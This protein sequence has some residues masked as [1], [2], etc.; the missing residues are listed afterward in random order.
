MYFSRIYAVDE[1]GN[2]YESLYWQRCPA[3]GHV[4]T[5]DCE[6]HVCHR[7]GRAKYENDDL[8]LVGG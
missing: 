4:S 5:P 8:Y 2:V 6:G 7:C 1:Q 3:C